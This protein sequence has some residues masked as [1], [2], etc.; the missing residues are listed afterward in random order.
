MEDVSD[1]FVEALTMLD[2]VADE[3]P[4]DEAVKELDDITLQVFWR[5][6]PHLS[7][8]AGALWRRLNAELSRPA[9]PARDSD[10]DEVGGEGG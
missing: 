6:W 7:S 2:R 9:T 1:R 5:D 10:L 4:V 8:W 3:L